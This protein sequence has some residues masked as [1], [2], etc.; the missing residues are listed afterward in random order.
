M[1]EIKKEETKQCRGRGRKLFW[2]VAL[3]AGVLIGASF[4]AGYGRHR[5]YR[6]ELTEEELLHRMSRG[7]AWALSRVDATEEQRAQIDAILAELAPDMRK[8]RNARRALMDQF[9]QAVEADKVS[10][11]ELVRIQT[12]GLSL[13]ERAFRRSADVVVKVSAVL[14]PEQRK[15]LTEAWG[16]RR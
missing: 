10:P 2:G 4:F 14:T 13:A 8:L 15:E 12:T 16:H 9:I 1:S 7:T 11:D 3:I 6:G 5:W